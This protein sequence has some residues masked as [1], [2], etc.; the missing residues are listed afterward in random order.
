LFC[1]S[2]QSLLCLANLGRLNGEDSGEEEEPEDQKLYRKFI[3]SIATDTNDGFL[4]PF[5]FFFSFLCLP[6][7]FL[8]LFFLSDLLN[9]DD[10][11]YQPHK[12]D[13]EAEELDEAAGRIS[14]S[15][16]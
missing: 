1:L 7:F 3:S 2:S 16:L 11:E 5:F 13:D 10:Q 9:D 4:N 12:S 14:S 15:V 8:S 6:F